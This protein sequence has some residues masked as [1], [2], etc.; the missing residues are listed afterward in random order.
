MLP[1]G[2]LLLRILV[3]FWIALDSIGESQSEKRSRKRDRDRTFRIFRSS[4]SIL[5]RDIKGV[6]RVY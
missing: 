6:G 4:R 1:S 5:C 2:A 3:Y